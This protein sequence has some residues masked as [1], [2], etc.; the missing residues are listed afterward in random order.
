MR[1][2]YTNLDLDKTR[3]EIRTITLLPGDETDS[4]QCILHKISLDDDDPAYEALSYVWGA[5]KNTEEIWLNEIL[6]P[7]TQNLHIALLHLRHTEES[8]T[9]WIDALCINQE[10]IQERNQQV[11]LMSKVY[12]S[13]LQVLVWLGE[14]N[15]KIG[16]AI[17]QMKLPEEELNKLDKATMKRIGAE[18]YGLQE[19]PWFRYE[20][21]FRD[22]NV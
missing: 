22:S 2:P 19:R 14:G 17:E 16:W 3:H 8:R 20:D 10:N 6:T 15:D 4:I 13:A 18:V 1:T 7:V 11:E 9:L 21:H 12:S 5:S